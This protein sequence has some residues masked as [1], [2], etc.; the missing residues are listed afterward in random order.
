MC[1]CVLKLLF[2]VVVFLTKTL[3]CLLFHK[4]TCSVTHYK[5]VIEALL[6]RS[7][8]IPF[9]EEIWILILSLDDSG[10][11]CPTTQSNP[12]I[13]KPWWLTWMH[14]RLVIRR[15]WVQPPP[16]RLHSFLEIN[17]EIY[18]K[19]FLPLIQEGQL[20]FSGK[21][22]GTILVNDLED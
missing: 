13:S 17:H 2:C 1:V 22:M 21:R 20:S 9:N 19:V 4:N 3:C 18:S 11:F 6:M 15:L 5:P 12:F 8:S 10:S 7:P 14:V 16:G